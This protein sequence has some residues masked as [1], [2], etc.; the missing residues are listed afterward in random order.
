MLKPNH[1]NGGVNY[2]LFF[3]E[4]YFCGIKNDYRT[5]MCYIYT[6]LKGLLTPARG[7]RIMLIFFVIM[8][9]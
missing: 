8:L 1:H 7:W 2:I 9:C 5:S 3:V 6:L 4:H